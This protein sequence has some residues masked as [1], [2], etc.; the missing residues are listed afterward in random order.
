ML[1]NACCPPSTWQHRPA[2]VTAVPVVSR[3]VDPSRSTACLRV[4]KLFIRAP[5]SQGPGPASAAFHR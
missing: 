5:S 3:L 2:V 4:L 1:H